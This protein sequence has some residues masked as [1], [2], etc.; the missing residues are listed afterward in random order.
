MSPLVKSVPLT[1]S[2]IR[3]KER[4]T[5]DDEVGR[6]QYEQRDWAYGVSSDVFPASLGMSLPPIT[7][8]LEIEYKKRLRPVD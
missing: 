6:I 1:G 4:R 8:I 5:N 3:R 7:L 2:K